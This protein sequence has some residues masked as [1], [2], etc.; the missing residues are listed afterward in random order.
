MDPTSAASQSASDGAAAA[1]ATTPTPTAAVAAP[2]KA[3][4]LLFARYHIA[5]TETLLATVTKAEVWSKPASCLFFDT[6][7]GTIN[8]IAGVDEFWRRRLQGGDYSEFAPLYANKVAESGVTD[9][10]LWTARNP[11]WAV[12]SRAAVEAAQATHD[13]IAKLS[14]EDLLAFAEYHSTNGTPQ[15]IQRG[16]ALL[17]LLNH[18]THHRGQAHAALSSFGVPTP[19]LD[20]TLVMG[21][22]NC[23][24]TTTSAP[25]PL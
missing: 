1:A 21:I 19:P 20:I 23:V 10:A 18:A 5:A 3:V 14:E 8:H 2:T 9:G 6:I 17:H 24:L 25:S 13:Y 7:H 22:P 12:A 16:A 11:D 15:K 4:L